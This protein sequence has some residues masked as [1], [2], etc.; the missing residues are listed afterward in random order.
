MVLLKLESGTMLNDCELAERAVAAE[1]G[2]ELLQVP[3]EDVT[4]RMVWYST[5]AIYN[6]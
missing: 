5:V 4:K 6:F 3:L 1:I 2:R